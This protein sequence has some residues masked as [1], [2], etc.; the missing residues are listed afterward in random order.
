MTDIFKRREGVT[1]LLE[2]NE[3]WEFEI[4]EKNFLV[5]TTFVRIKLL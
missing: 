5:G 2:K 4:V 3:S 1:G